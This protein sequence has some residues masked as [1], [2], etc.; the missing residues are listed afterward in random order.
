MC[1]LDKEEFMK[2]IMIGFISLIMVLS[3]ASCS[4]KEEA[5]VIATVELSANFMDGF[6]NSDYDED[7]KNMIY[8]YNT[9][10]YD[11]KGNWVLNSTAVDSLERTIDENSGDVT[12]TYRI[13]DGLTWSDGE[14]LT[15]KDYVFAVLLSAS[16]EW[17]AVG[18][19]DPTY[20]HVLGYAEYSQGYDPNGVSDIVYLKE[21][22]EDMRKQYE[23]EGSVFDEEHYQLDEAGKRIPIAGVELDETGMPLLDDNGEY[24]TIP[25]EKEDDNGTLSGVILHDDLSFSITLD[26]TLLPYFNEEILAMATPMPMHVMTDH[27]G[28]IESDET[29]SRL[30]GYDLDDACAYAK[31]TYRK[32]PDVSSGPYTFVSY[33]DKMVTLKRNEEFKGDFRGNVPEID[34]IIVKEI[35]P[36]KH[37]DALLAGDVDL[38]SNIIEGDEIKKA[39]GRDDIKSE[40]YYSNSFGNLA[41]SCDFGP[42]S[43]EYVRRAIAYAFDDNELINQ[44]LGG[45]AKPVYSDYGYAQWMYE[46][47]ADVI[48]SLNPY[49]FNLEKAKE[50]LNNSSYV[51]E[52]DGIT[53]FDETKASAD[54]IRYNAN[55]EPLILNHLGTSDNTVTEN[56]DLQLSENLP[57][58]GIKFTY[59]YSDFTSIMM[60]YYHGTTMPLENRKYHM[61]NLAS[62]MGPGYEPYYNFHG[63]YAGSSANPSGIND[64]VLNKTMEDMMMSD[65]TMKEEYLEAWVAYQKRFNEVLPVVPLYTSEDHVFYSDRIKGVLVNSMET[66]AH[67][68]SSIRWNK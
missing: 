42:T 21:D 66:Y 24:V 7:I 51:F 58:L 48:D 14:A 68:I 6:G 26:G 59:E 49:A 60:N 10:D 30:T 54:Y 53:P 62:V 63:D 1:G 3:S 37:M 38:V 56:I 46:R 16:D 65:P 31:N 34:T 47:S 11:E 33:K 45:Y 55:K 9:Y 41:F 28:V 39:E 50:E 13:K 29:G 61:Y 64:E 2:R 36:S 19:A 8:G 27:K 17:I 32:G 18:A 23:S 57:K 20:D 22:D 4:S 25:R 43:D 5:L 12:Y 40:S 67:S 15:A 44:A 35:D 52:A